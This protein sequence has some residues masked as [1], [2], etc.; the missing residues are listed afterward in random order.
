MLDQFH[1]LPTHAL[2]VHLTVIALPVAALGGILVALVP[3]VRRRY[4]VPILLVGVLAAVLMPVTIKSGEYLYAQRS[5]AF[6]AADLTEAGLMQHHEDLA[7]AL[8]KWVVLLMIG[9]F[10]VVVPPLLVRWD[11]SR[12]GFHSR[13]R[14][15]GSAGRPGPGGPSGRL[16][17]TFLFTCRPVGVFLRLRLT[18]R[19]DR[20]FPM[21]VEAAQNLVS[22]TELLGEFLHVT[23]NR[24]KLAV[25]LRE[26]EH[27]GDAVTHRI[28]PRAELDL[29]HPVRPRGHLPAG[30]P[31]RRRH[32]LDRGG[33]PTSSCCPSSET[34]PAEMCRQVDL[35]QRAAAR[36][37]PTRWAAAGDDERPRVVLDRGQPAGE[38]GRPGLPRAAVPAVQRRV[39]RADRAEAQAGRR[40]PRGG[41]RR[42]SS[43]WPNVV[44]TI[45]VKES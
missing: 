16:V 6:T 13:G 24:E 17:G 10:L 19:D 33:R 14:A 26:H 29:R 7:L 32:G 43:T 28:M 2:I 40:R 1:G 3:W 21:F 41:R 11:R 9:L 38:R 5:A 4:G 36:A 35:L 18:P 20:F 37:R 44:E 23:S 45:A 25:Q 31:A 34:L 8:P 15:G 22:A 27:A 30:H 12:S 39:R 42:A